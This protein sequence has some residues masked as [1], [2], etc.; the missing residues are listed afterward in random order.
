VVQVV[1]A[2]VTLPISIADF[3]ALQAQYIAAV[4]AAAGVDPSQVII[5]SITDGV[6][7]GG[8]RL[9]NLGGGPPSRMSV[10]I[11]TSIYGSAHTGAPHRALRD[12]DAQLVRAG[13]PAQ[14][15]TIQVFLH[16]EVKGAAPLMRSLPRGEVLP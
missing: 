6:G 12:L 3:A 15:R 11:H 2:E 14:S 5:V 16:R 10:E 9:L 4:A 7:G 1:H 13:L 8:R